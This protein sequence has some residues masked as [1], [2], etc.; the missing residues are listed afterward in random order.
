MQ[1]SYKTRALTSL[2]TDVKN[3][4][5]LFNSPIQR[6]EGQWKPLQK[7]ELI[8]SLLRNIPV[9]PTYV[10]V[11]EDKKL[12]IVDGIQ[13][14]S[15]ICDFIKGD[16]QLAKT[17]KP[18]E[19]NGTERIIAGKKFAKLDSDVQ[20]KLLAAEIQVVELTDYS[21][22]DIR[23]MFRRQNNGVPLVKTQKMVVNCSD[24]LLNKLADVMNH[25]FWKKTALSSG[26]IKRDES[27]NIILGAMALM[28]NEY[29]IK[30]FKAEALYEDFVP[31]LESIDEDALFARVEDAITKLNELIVSKQKNAKKVSLPMI[32][33]G[34]D[35]CIKDKKSTTK[36]VSYLVD[37]FFANYDTNEEYHA[38]CKD[39]SASK[40][41]V[42]ARRDY[43]KTVINK[44]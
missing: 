13:R 33:W 20:E 30:S 2:V 3:E 31:F 38:L 23:E 40:E 32:I 44:L 5:Y 37:D 29:E 8:D 11:T 35:K 25:D 7:S 14:I 24:E 15:N 18:I 42:L 4:K 1:C 9:N 36:F 22:E 6:K 39:G 43:F 21:D 16:F 12:S 10:A 41:K 28:C 34:M 19:I 27:R 17:L 26:Q